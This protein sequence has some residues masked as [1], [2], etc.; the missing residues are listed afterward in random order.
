VLLITVLFGDRPALAAAAFVGCYALG[1]IAGVGSALLARRTILRGASRPMAL[2]LPSY[3]LPSIKAALMTTYDRG[4]VF[5]KKAGSVILMICIVLWWLGAYPHVEPPAEAAAIRAQVA[6]AAENG[7]IAKGQ[8]AKEEADALL[9]NADELEARHASA[10]SFIGRIGRGVQ[11]VFGPLGF[12]WQLTIGVMSSFA[13]R[14]VF[15]STMSVVL[16]GQ[17]ELDEETVKSRL[18]GATRD[19]GVTPVFSK[20]ASWALLVFYVLAMQCLPTLAVTAR[21]SGSWK[22]AVLQLGWMSAVA[23]GAALIAYQVARAMGV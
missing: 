8:M 5:L 17:E 3:K 20:G 21:E 14:E 15:V 6:A 4:L 13:A 9:A 18:I 19:D 12:D 11:P 7:Q 10:N 22:W 23:Y 1:M 2:E 16:A